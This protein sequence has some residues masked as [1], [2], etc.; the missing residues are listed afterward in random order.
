VNVPVFITE[1]GQGGG[2]YITDQTISCADVVRDVL[3]YT[4]QLEE[5]PYVVGFHLWSVG[6]GTIWRDL[7]SCLDMIG[8]ALL[9]YYGK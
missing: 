7:T 1:W 3:Q 8:P 5:D 6:S 4:Y 2:T 9:Q